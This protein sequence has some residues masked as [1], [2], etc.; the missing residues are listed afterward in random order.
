MSM[1]I[2]FKQLSDRRN[3]EAVPALELEEAVADKR[4]VW[5]SGHK[6]LDITNKQQY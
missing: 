6:L 5:R 1:L 3:S 4:T 2:S